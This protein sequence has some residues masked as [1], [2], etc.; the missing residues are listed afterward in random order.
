M[1]RH[2]ED[3][4]LILCQELTKAFVRFI[5]KRL[6]LFKIVFSTTHEI[7]DCKCLRTYVY[8]EN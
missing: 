3:V 1:S 8:V 5:A 4:C 2:R 7:K 6:A